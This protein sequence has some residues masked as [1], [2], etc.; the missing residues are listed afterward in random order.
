MAWD[1]WERLKA[2]TARGASTH[3]RINHLPAEGGGGTGDLVVHQDD[4]GAV[5]HVPI[6]GAP[7]EWASE[8]IQESIMKSIE[9]DTSSEAETQA[10]EEYT[11][12]RQAALD[13]A[14]AAVDHALVNNNTIDPDTAEDLRRAARTSAGHSHSDGAQ[15]KSESSGH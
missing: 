3:T 13:S 8:D 5:G 2:G 12:G 15:W 11:N 14:R 1:E 7:L 9:Q 10:G 4:L 6:A